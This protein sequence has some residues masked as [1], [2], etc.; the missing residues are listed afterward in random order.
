[1]LIA[2]V[3]AKV[4]TALHSMVTMKLT[5]R[6]VERIALPHLEFSVRRLGD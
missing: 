5:R 1:V 6:Q 2:K 3:S 4:G